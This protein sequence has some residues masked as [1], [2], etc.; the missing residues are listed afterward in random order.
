MPVRNGEAYLNNSIFDITQNIRENDEVIVI[1]DGSTDGTWKLLSQWAS[2]DQ[3]VKIFKGSG[4]GLVSSLNFGINQAQNN[5]IARFDVD[6]KYSK[7]RL[8]LQ[9]ASIDDS[10]V[11]IFSDYAFWSKERKNL[12]VI[13]SAVDFRAV[14]VSLLTSQ[15]TPH[16]VALF[17]KTVFLEAGGYR[18]EDFPA[19]DISLWLRMSRMGQIKTVPKILLNYQLNSTSVSGKK[20]KVAKDLTQKLIKDIGIHV[21]TLHKLCDD[22]EEVIDS[23]DQY[24]FVHER[25]ILLAKDFYA[26]IQ[27]GFIPLE[28]ERKVRKI[29]FSAL[30][31]FYA[32]PAIIKLMNERKARNNYRKRYFR[33]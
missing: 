5:W 6:D 23:Y 29:I 1:D 17:S 18:K 12:G 14:P 24:D 28:I 3:R 10:T 16:P 21:D 13:P 15:R 11:L 30:T 7:N 26:A 32:V 22:W 31:S 19:E 20:Y 9:R 4:K 25:R 27:Y 33:S 2:T 8:T